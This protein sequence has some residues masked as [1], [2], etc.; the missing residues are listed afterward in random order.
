MEKH[1][2]PFPTFVP[3]SCFQKTFSPK[4]NIF[5]FQEIGKI[6]TTNK[7]IKNTMLYRLRM[8]L[9]TYSQTFNSNLCFYHV[10]SVN[11]QI[12]TGH[13]FSIQIF[14][15]VLCF[16]PSLS[17]FSSFWFMCRNRQII[18]K[19]FIFLFNTFSLW[20]T[21]SISR[22]SYSNQPWERERE[23]GSFL[24]GFQSIWYFTKVAFK[25]GIYY[26]MITQVKFQLSKLFIIWL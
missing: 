2:R 5:K 24:I 13:D 18:K 23:S 11:T 9:C 1:E 19:K 26:N 7:L 15:P 22:C 12:I 3:F 25:Y 14:G 4:P 16:L 8:F 17:H 20:K 21:P 10:L 6:I